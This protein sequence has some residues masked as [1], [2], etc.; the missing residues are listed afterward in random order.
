MELRKAEERLL[1]RIVL[2]GPLRPAGRDLQPARALNQLG[3]VRVVPSRCPAV[4]PFY[5]ASGAGLLAE[6]DL[7]GAM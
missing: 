4:T 6:R 3:L 1:H 2:D 7:A 5:V